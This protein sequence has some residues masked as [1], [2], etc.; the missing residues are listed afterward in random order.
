M[1]SGRRPTPTAWVHGP[2]AEDLARPRRPSRRASTARAARLRGRGAEEARG[3]AVARQALRATPRVTSSSAVLAGPPPRHG[4]LRH[5]SSQ[6]AKAAVEPRH[7]PQTPGR[8]STSLAA[9]GGELLAAYR[10]AVQG[11]SKRWTARTAD[12]ADDRTGATR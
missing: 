2:S 7:G 10:S 5:R 8:H 12:P 11:R 4:W 1:R 9:A 3:H 6:Q